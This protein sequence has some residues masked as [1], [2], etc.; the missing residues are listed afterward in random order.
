M[1]LFLIIINTKNE[2][3]FRYYQVRWWLMQI[4]RFLQSLFSSY[5]IIDFYMCIF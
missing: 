2:R 4:E 5:I 1:I 3:N